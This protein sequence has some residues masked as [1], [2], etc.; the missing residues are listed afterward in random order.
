[1]NNIQ[2]EKNEN[3][4]LDVRVLVPIQRHELLVDLFKDL[5]VGESFIFINDHD[6]IPLYYEFKSIYGDVVDWVYL[7]RGGRD[8]KVKVTR[9]E[10]SK[11]RDMSEIDTLLDLRNVEPKE[12][13]HIVFHRYGMMVTG[14]VM[15]LIS[16][17]EPEEIHEIFENKFQGQFIWTYKKQVPDE[18]VVHIKKNE[19]SG[20]GEEGFALVNEFDIRPYPPTERH[21]MFYQAFAEIQPGEAF[22]FINDHDP[23]PLYYQM[24]AESKEPFRWEYL[25]QG[26]E[27]WKVRVVKVK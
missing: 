12:W 18:V 14:S 17:I 1:M 6:P 24:E 16:K 19:K 23:K 26:P 5:P 15:E 2:L 9:T 25:E 13:K 4:E 20:L 11:A 21:E 8:W 27:V 22:T 3:G 7:N 10:A